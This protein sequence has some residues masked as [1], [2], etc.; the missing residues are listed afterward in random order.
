MAV[1]SWRL[2]CS[3]MLERLSSAKSAQRLS[4][5]ALSAQKQKQRVRLRVAHA[6]LAAYNIQKSAALLA[7]ELG[8]NFTCAFSACPNSD[9]I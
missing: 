6:Q 4:V 1:A 9:A 2:T 3:A 7:I 5:E 8:L